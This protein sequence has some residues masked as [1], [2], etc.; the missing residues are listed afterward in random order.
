MP[1][2]RTEFTLELHFI[3]WTLVSSR[4]VA[5]RKRDTPGTMQA[6]YGSDIVTCLFCGDFQPYQTHA[7]RAYPPSLVI[8]TRAKWDFLCAAFIQPCNS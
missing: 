3:S 8:A 7:S 1:N 6:V 5:D 4:I 2:H